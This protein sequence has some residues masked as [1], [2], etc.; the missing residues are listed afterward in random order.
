M[1]FLLFLDLERIDVIIVFNIPIRNT[2]I[3]EEAPVI[4]SMKELGYEESK[5]EN[6]NIRIDKLNDDIAI[7]YY[8]LSLDGMIEEQS[9]FL[10]FKIYNTSSNEEAILKLEEEVIEY[11]NRINKLT[12]TSGNCY[13]PNVTFENIVKQWVEL[14]TAVWNI[15]AGYSTIDYQNIPTDYTGWF[16]V[17]TVKDHQMMH[18]RIGKDIEMSEKNI[19]TICDILNRT[20]Q[21]FQ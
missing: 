4:F 21:V 5:I 11:Q 20:N 9:V 10:E 15:D 3:S 18:V 16:E 8:D 6:S 13:Y 14:D 1:F 12:C 2:N 7:K 17:F 19:Q